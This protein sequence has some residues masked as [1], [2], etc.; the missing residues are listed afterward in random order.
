MELTYATFDGLRLRVFV[1]HFALTR[2]A[3]RPGHRALSVLSLNHRLS[4]LFTQLLAQPQHRIFDLCQVGPRG[5][6]RPIQQFI[7]RPFGFR[8]QFRS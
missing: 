7:D 8:Q 5:L 4:G 2:R 1:M 3:E 6:I